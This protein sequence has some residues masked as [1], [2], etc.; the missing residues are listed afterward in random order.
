V[1]ALVLVVACLLV[2]LVAIG[3]HGSLRP[4]SSTTTSGPPGSNPSNS[5]T[6]TSPGKGSGSQSTDPSGESL[7]A[8]PPA[9]YHQVFSDDFTGTTLDSNWYA[10]PL[11]QANPQAGYWN[12]SHIIVG[13]GLATIKTY[14]DP[15]FNGNWT[16]A[17]MSSKPGLVQTYGE[18]L[19]R[20][21]VTSSAGI[22]FT[23]LL[24]N[25][26]DSGSPEVD[27]NESNGTSS[28]TYGNL[29]WMNRGFDRRVNL[30][31]DLT[32]WHTWGIIWTPTSLQFTVDGSVWA[33]MDPAGYIPNG[34]MV[35]DLQ[36]HT[37]SCDNSF[38]KVCP[39]SSTPPLSE[40]QIDW[41]VAYHHN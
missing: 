9:G 19:V 3:G 37:W 8:A 12:P 36:G 24:W 1:V 13:G 21:R 5:S 22:S 17:G 15:A 11:R 20:S 7:P 41:V 35:L 2:V 29:I 32:Q 23:E 39:N 30:S 38:H 4:N 31:V 10:Y 33:T 14:Q 26:N 18:Y 40:L 34:P 25:A 27:F 28:E 16:S 6:T